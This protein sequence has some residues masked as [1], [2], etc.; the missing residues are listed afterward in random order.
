MCPG[1][2]PT[3]IGRAPGRNEK[4]P[5]GSGKKYKVCCGVG[6]VAPNLPDERDG[7]GWDYFR[8]AMADT[9]RRCLPSA[10]PILAL[11][12]KYDRFFG[13]LVS[14]D[15]GTYGERPQDLMACAMGVRAFRLTIGALWL[16]LSGYTDITPSLSRGVWEIGLRLA[17]AEQDPRAATLGTWLRD[18]WKEKKA[19]QALA[20]REGVDGARKAMEA[21]VQLKGLELDKLTKQAASLGF[22]PDAIRKKYGAATIRDVC[23]DLGVP[24]AYEGSYAWYSAYTHNRSQVLSDFSRKVGNERLF[25]AGPKYH[26]EWLVFAACTMQHLATAAINA[27][28]LVEDRALL[29][30][31]MTLA[32]QVDDI[33]RSAGVYQGDADE[34]RPT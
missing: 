16:A 18:A 29:R 20:L 4:C 33:A 34:N 22:D 2:P 27:A 26:E 5:C 13:R 1:I 8:F 11:V 14:R 30:E 12:Q 28:R 25:E 32:D 24:D 21:H 10:T 9:Y 7:L 19:M 23:D 6:A 17:H 15:L 3:S 31:A